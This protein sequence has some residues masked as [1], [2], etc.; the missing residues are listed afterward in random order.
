M[1]YSSHIYITTTTATTTVG[2][3]EMHGGTVK[4]TSEGE[5]KGCTF[6]LELPLFRDPGLRGSFD[7]ESMQKLPAGTAAALSGVVA[8]DHH[9]TTTTSAVG[10]GGGGIGGPEEENIEIR[11]YTENINITNNNEDE[12]NND[13]VMNTNIYQ[14]QQSQQQQQLQPLRNS[15]INKILHAGSN[16]HKQF[17][18]QNVKFTMNLTSSSYLSRSSSSRIDNSGIDG[19]SSKNQYCIN[20]IEDYSGSQFP[21]LER[22][23]SL[24]PDLERMD[25]L[26]SLDRQAS[27]SRVNKANVK[28]SKRNQYSSSMVV[29]VESDKDSKAS[30]ESLAGTTILVEEHMIDLEAQQTSTERESMQQPISTEEPA[31][32]VTSRRKSWESKLTI[33]AVDDTALSRK[34]MARLLRTAGHEVLEAEDGVDC[35][36]V[37]HCTVQGPAVPL[38]GSNRSGNIGLNTAVDIILIDENMPNMTGPE[39]TKRLRDCGYSGLIIGVTGDCYQDQIAHFI[40]EGAN[41]VL[42]KPLRLESLRAKLHELWSKT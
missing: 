39:A 20:N 30:S 35:L 1:F 7:L 38:S 2:I 40:Q 18:N 9:H 12:N 5:G 34:M 3:V 24:F 6:I 23:N 22:M 14:Q 26:S 17:L 16:L 19:M 36:Q 37:M 27:M 4:A 42:P 29:P 13:V 10:G 8:V 33:L 32:T 31:V 11:Q 25:S 41:A 15:L 21:D 28:S